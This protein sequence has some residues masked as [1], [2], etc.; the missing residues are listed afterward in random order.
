MSEWAEV[1]SAGL[2]EVCDAG[3]I[4]VI[5]TSAAAE[6][7]AAARRLA[8]IAELVTRR[9][10]SD[11]GRE[12]ELWACDGWDS[13]AA[14]IAAAQGIGHRAASTL[15]HEGLALRDRLP[16]L[17]ALLAQGVIAARTATTV[18]WRTHLITDPDTLAAVDAELAAAITGWGALSPAKLDTQLDVLIDRHDPAAVLSQ[19]AAARRRDVQLGAPDDEAGT[20]SLWGRLLATDGALLTRRLDA[21]AQA[22]C[23]TDPRTVGER[24]SDALGILAAGGQVLPCR[25]G[26]PDCPHTSPDAR[27][28]AIVITVLTNHHPQPTGPNPPTEPSG[29]SGPGD[30]SGAAGPAGP[31]GPSGPAG[32]SGATGRSGPD[33]P[34]APS[35]STGPGPGAPAPP[36]ELR[37]PSRSNPPAAP[38]ATPDCGPPDTALDSGPPT[39]T[40]GCGPPVTALIAGGPALPIALL[41]ELSRIGALTHVLPDPATLGAEPGYRPTPKLTRFLRARDLTC[42]FPGCDRPAEHCDLDHRHPHR[43]GGPTHPANLRCLCRKH[44]LLKTFWTGPSGWTDHQLDDGTIIWTAPTGHHYRSP[45]PAALYFPH[46]NTTTP[47]PPTPPTQTPGSQRTLAMPQRKHPRRTTHTNRIH[48]QRHHNQHLIDTNPAPY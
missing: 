4:E 26:A 27:A 6:A 20:T 14:E 2:A 17:G 42:R 34:N 12:R 38:P 13:A 41:D 32:L 22:V 33:Q 5:T 16:Q 9:C 19:R 30:P 35:S 29:P 48:T 3:L 25:C 23:R 7:R 43:D 46:W 37:G 10:D 31:G 24:R 28:E 45:P 44:H 8:A 21:M 39:A 18:A 15:M 36:R 1:G 11:Q 40:R 47:V